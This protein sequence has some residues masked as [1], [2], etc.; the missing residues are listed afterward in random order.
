MEEQ[1]CKK[2]IEE[3]KDSLSQERNAKIHASE[4][5]GVKAV[6]EVASSFIADNGFELTHA[7]T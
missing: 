3:Q 6:N 4:E 2:T 7:S 5:T 1:I